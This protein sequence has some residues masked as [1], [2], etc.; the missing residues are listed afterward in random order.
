MS[1]YIKETVGDVTVEIGYNTLG[2]LQARL[3]EIDPNTNHQGPPYE[4]VEV[5]TVDPH[6]PEQPEERKGLY[7][8]YWPGTHVGTAWVHETVEAALADI[9]E[10]DCGTPQLYELGRE[11]PLKK[12]TVYEQLNKVGVKW[13]VE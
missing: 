1:Y 9:N 8:I 12:R 3:R 6:E 10:A 5:E 4:A 2:E 13:S 7:L 11:I